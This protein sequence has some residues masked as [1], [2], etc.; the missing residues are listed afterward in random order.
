[1]DIAQLFN[2]IDPLAIIITG[3]VTAFILLIIGISI[4]VTTDRKTL[5]LERLGRYI[6]EDE[7]LSEKE[8]STPLTDWL[9]RSVERS[10]IGDKISKSLSRADLKW[11]PGE[12]IALILIAAFV[13]GFVLWYIGG[14][15]IAVGIIGAIIGGFLPRMYVNSQQKK[16]L[17]KFDLQ[18][19]DMLNLMVNG[20]RAGFSTMQAMEAV[21]RELPAPICDEFRRVVQE[22]Q[23][24]VSMEKALDNLLVRIPSD[25]L[26]LTITAI[27]VQ[28]EV[29]G[30]LAEIMETISHTIRERIRIK[31]EI[32]VL[33]TQVMYSGRFL[34]LLPFFVIGIIYLLNR[35]YIMEFF[36]PENVPCG[37][38]ALAVAG[39]LIFLGYLVMNKLGDIEV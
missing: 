39:L 31:G 9:N 27:N 13:V 30:N 28:R 26:D 37:Y 10:S 2:Q 36:K 8:R 29:G 16:R 5:E 24:G 33:T 12:F 23:L 1:M 17:V 11:K 34:S 14:R 38:I 21:S 18:L 35:E 3:G 32:R 7:V 22:M 6:E 4:T 15:V 20:L 25:D 19:P